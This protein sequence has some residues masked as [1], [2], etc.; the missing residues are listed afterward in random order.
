MSDTNSRDDLKY[1]T[2]DNDEFTLESILAEFKGSAYI[3]GDTKTSPELLN[4]RIR[5]IV[6]ESK[7]GS[8]AHTE[9]YAEKSSDDAIRWKNVEETTAAMAAQPI[10]ELS[11]ED[12]KLAAKTAEIDW[13]PVKAATSFDEAR[14]E[15]QAFFAKRDEAVKRQEEELLK[16]RWEEERHRKEELLKNPT[17]Q[18]EE[19][20][21]EESDIRSEDDGEKS[22]N[23]ERE[24]S[25]DA[26]ADTESSTDE[27]SDRGP[28]ILFFDN[29]RYADSHE[30]ETAAQDRDYTLSEEEEAEDE[31]TNITGSFFARLFHRRRADMEMPENDEFTEDEETLDD[32]D[33]DIAG[34]FFARLFHRRKA[35]GEMP[36]NDEFTEVG[37]EPEDEAEEVPVF[38]PEME[39]EVYIEEPD[40][41]LEAQSLGRQCR[42]LRIKSRLGL[43]LSVIMTTLTLLLE[44]GAE[45]PIIGS[46]QKLITAVLVIMQL[47]VMALSLEALRRGFAELIKREPGAET[48]VLFSNIVTYIACCWYLYTGSESVGAPFCAVSAFSAAFAQWGEYRSLGAM[49]LSL[50]TAAS[51]AAP[52]GL[53][54]KYVKELDRTV[55]KRL[56]DGQGGFYN[57]LVEADPSELTYRYFAPLIMFTAVLLSVVSAIGSKC[58]FIHCFAA[59]TAACASFTALSAF[60]IPF[61]VIARKLRSDGAA[62]AG[63]GG[64]DDIYYADGVRITDADLFPGGASVTGV[65]VFEGIKSDKVIRYTSSIMMA[66]ESDLTQAFSDFINRQ[67]LAAAKVESFD[68]TEGGVCAVIRGERVICGTA[69]CMALFGIHIPQSMNVKNAMYTAINDS[70]AGAFIISY[71]PSRIVQTS[72][73]TMLKARVKLYFAMRDFNIT[74]LMVQQKLQIPVDDIEYLP[75]HDSYELTK[76]E[77]DAV[78]HS[79]AVLSRDIPTAFADTIAAARRL[80]LITVVNTV[81]SV[82]TTLLGM[83]IMFFM[84]WKGSAESVSPFN[85]AVYMLA[86]QAAVYF[87]SRTVTAF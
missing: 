11:P 21:N 1:T 3:A 40:F 44:R 18:E 75:A 79:A 7:D 26:A 20:E 22:E 70:L 77:T 54:C 81:L 85:L 71:T 53:S 34:S 56:P 58:S 49:R 39:P 82:V 9:L 17:Q 41:V 63:W 57:N 55:I 27:K 60:S 87:V 13:K 76:D 42:S 30:G 47:V 46:D 68:C 14:R 43:L 50:K 84:C 80:R 83:V 23:A 51:A 32:E 59:V 19:P 72:L 69:A 33:S 38:E 25:T 48:L 73:L 10:I 52:K 28:E 67:G 78:P 65:K 16:K 74:P 12:K 86:C 2:E 66:T 61:S 37:E 45:L 4:E 15:M 8:A 64:A 35:V 62:I 6:I 36:E 31:D 29:Y 5:Q 24:D